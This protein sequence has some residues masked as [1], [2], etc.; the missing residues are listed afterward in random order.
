VIELDQ[1]ISA[2]KVGAAVKYKIARKRDVSIWS[3]QPWEYKE[4]TI[5]PN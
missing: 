2:A 3:R 5:V 4:G 1:A